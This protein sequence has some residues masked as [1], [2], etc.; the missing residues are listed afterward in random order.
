MEKPWRCLGSLLPGFVEVEI[1]DVEVE[2]TDAEV[3]L[4]DAEVELTD[5]VGLTGAVV[6]SGGGVLPAVVSG[7]VTA[8]VVGRT[9]GGVLPTVVCGRVTAFVVGRTGGG[10]LPTV[11]VDDICV[12]STGGMLEA[13][14]G[15][16]GGGV[17]LEV[18]GVGGAVEG[19]VVTS[20]T[21]GV[22]VAV[23]GGFV[24]GV[25]GGLVV[26]VVG[27]L[28]VAVVGVVGGLVV[29][30][31]GVVGGLVV[32]VVGRLVVAVV[33]VVGGLVVAVVGVVGG[34]VVAVVGVV[35]GLVVAVVGGLVVAVVGVVGGLVVAVV[36]GL[37]VAVVGLVVGEV[38]GFLVDSVSG[39]VV[40]FTEPVSFGTSTG[41]TPEASSVA[42]ENVPRTKRKMHMMVTKSSHNRKKFS[43][44]HCIL[45]M[46]VAIDF[47][48]GCVPQNYQSDHGYSHISSYSFSVFKRTFFSKDVDCMCL[49]PFVV[50]AAVVM[51]FWF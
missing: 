42:P 49:S 41:P 24:V 12:V 33:G 32:A 29:A 36:G 11:V 40:V 51:L 3:E 20:T 38:T 50:V 2:L 28:V 5:N 27:G 14:V 9:G 17:T 6:E 44:T 8:F 25:V 16:N 13:G 39:A 18:A 46:F 22:V 21:L 34:L 10:V 23:V 15:R 43:H 7:R 47:F 26:A 31:V 37:V 1:T 35:G 4:T 48:F 45:Y 30:V 19:T